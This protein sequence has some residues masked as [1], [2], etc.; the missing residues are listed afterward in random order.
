MVVF[1]FFFDHFVSRVLG[2]GVILLE[3]ANA[4]CG[5]LKYLK[6]LRLEGFLKQLK[7]R[8]VFESFMGLG[9]KVLIY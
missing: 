6:E 2:Y 8:G 5:L 3:R 4:F 7:K 9:G 1:F